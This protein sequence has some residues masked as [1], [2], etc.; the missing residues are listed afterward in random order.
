MVLV[1]CFCVLAFSIFTTFSQKFFVVLIFQ[2]KDHTDIPTCSKVYQVPMAIES[3]NGNKKFQWQQKV[4]MATNR[5]K[6][7]ESTKC[8]ARGLASYVIWACLQ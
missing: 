2:K 6:R 5:S 1:V 8:N 4:P 3:S 7:S